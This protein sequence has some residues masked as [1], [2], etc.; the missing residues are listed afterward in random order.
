MTIT[1]SDSSENFDNW[2]RFYSDVKKLESRAQGVKRTKGDNKT[3]L[4]YVKGKNKDTF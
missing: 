3:C 2:H 4:S 1:V